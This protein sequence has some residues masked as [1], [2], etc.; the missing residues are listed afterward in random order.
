ML[1]T[2]QHSVPVTGAFEDSFHW[3]KSEA[4]P[5]HCSGMCHSVTPTGGFDGLMKEEE[6]QEMEDQ[7]EED[8]EEE[9][10]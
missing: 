4:S 9:E 10:D 5:G 7:E 3:G 2:R 1:L 6:E 8:Q